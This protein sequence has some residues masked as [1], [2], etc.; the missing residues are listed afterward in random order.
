MR[1][2][3]SGSRARAKSWR[4]RECRCSKPVQSRMQLDLATCGRSDCWDAAFLTLGYVPS[5]EM[6]GRRAKST[7]P[8]KP[9]PRP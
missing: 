2:P 3:V 6:L 8:A 1:G 9:E 4:T 5:Q 7:L